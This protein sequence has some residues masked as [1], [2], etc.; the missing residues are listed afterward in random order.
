MIE[1]G[2]WKCE[3][4]AES[5]YPFK[6]RDFLRECANYV[7]KM[8]PEVKETLPLL[9]AGLVAFSVQIMCEKVNEYIPSKPE[10]WFTFS[11][12][13]QISMHKIPEEVKAKLS[14]GF[15]RANSPRL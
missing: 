3:I 9:T 14:P 4:C 8:L 13:V 6:L 12:N 1:S 15:V 7:Q 5:G 11:A 2:R 10:G